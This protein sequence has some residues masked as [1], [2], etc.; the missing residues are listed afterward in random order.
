MPSVSRTRRYS[1]AFVNVR[2]RTAD[3]YGNECPICLRSWC[4]DDICNRTMTQTNCCFQFLCAACANKISMICK[5]EE[6]CTAV[7][8]ICP[9]CRDI[10]KTASATLF[11]GT[12][13]P[14]KK[15][16]EHDITMQEEPEQ[17][18]E[19]EAEADPETELEVA[20]E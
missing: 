20:E 10:S 19:A 17:D 4:A 12:K 11:V 15:C 14:C 16:R 18:A 8:M 3:D 2:V 9:F 6:D 1:S 13:R 5:C 7:I